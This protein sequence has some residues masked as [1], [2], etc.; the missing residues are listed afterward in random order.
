MIETPIPGLNALRFPPRIALES[1]FTNCLESLPVPALVALAARSARQL[2]CKYQNPKRYY[3][4]VP[5]PIKVPNE[6]ES[7]QTLDSAIRFSEEVASLK[8]LVQAPELVDTLSNLLKATDRTLAYAID[9][10]RKTHAINPTP[11]PNDTC[12]WWENNLNDLVKYVERTANAARATKAAY[13]AYQAA[14]AQ[15]KRERHLVLQAA[16]LSVSLAYKVDRKVRHDTPWY[17]KFERFNDSSILEEGH[18]LFEISERE[19]WSDETPVYPG[20][21][22]PDA[23]IERTVMFAINDLCVNLCELVARDRK[24]LMFI[25]WRMLEQVIAAALA[26]LGFTV[27]LTRGSKDGGKDVIA[28]CFLKGKR[29]CYYIEVK[30]WTSLKKVKQTDIAHFIEV[31]VRDL[32]DGGLFLSTS[33]FAPKIFSHLSTIHKAR[34]RLGSDLKVVSLCQH[35]VQKRGQAVWEPQQVLPDV[36]FEHTI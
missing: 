25:E 7:R 13:C 33:G 6:K 14:T 18:I 19:K 5:L 27:E 21:F 29:Q 31:N 1:A 28:T 20:F 15:L 16:L 30:H 22:S 36:L 26:G 9:E 34:I 10:T 23:V 35:F 3:D 11:G 12:M 32:T 24:A 4:N 17:T 2:Q 8:H